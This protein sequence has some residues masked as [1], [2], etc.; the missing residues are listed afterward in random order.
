MQQKL[1]SSPNTLRTQVFLSMHTSLSTLET[2]EYT[3]QHLAKF[4][5][6]INHM[7]LSF[8]NSQASPG[9]EGRLL[10]SLTHLFYL[11]HIFMIK[12]PKTNISKRTIYT[13]LSTL[14]TW[15]T[16]SKHIFKNKVNVIP[17]NSILPMGASAM[18]GRLSTTTIT[19]TPQS[20]HVWGDYQYNLILQI[21]L[22]CFSNPQ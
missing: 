5:N 14:E 21:T 6:K 4:Q 8:S 19:T 10:I 11:I 13:S 15:N 17:S 1:T 12:Y 20:K 3:L 18:M 7:T 2:I 22:I 9:E 16:I